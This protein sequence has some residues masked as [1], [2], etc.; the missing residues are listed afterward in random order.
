MPKIV[1][2]NE[3]KERIAEAAWRIVRRE[4][5]DSVTVRRVADEMGMSLGS[6]RH[7]FNTHNELL[8]FCIEL[9][10]LRVNQRIQNLPFTGELRA[11]MELVIWELMPLDEERLGESEIWL[12]FAGRAASDASIRAISIAVHEEL[13]A[14]F[15]GMMERL[16]NRQTRSSID[17]EYEARRLHA[18]VDG[19]VVHCVTVPGKSGRRN[20]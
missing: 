20:C 16:K 15:K 17:V 12:A 11:D 9:L 5:L 8:A 13:Y 2:H 7:Y 1:D 10:S 19:L 3:R 4:G 18:L 6:V 14:A